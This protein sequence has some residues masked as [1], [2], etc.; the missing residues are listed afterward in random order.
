MKPLTERRRRGVSFRAKTDRQKDARVER[1]AQ[2][3]E[4][5]ERSDVNGEL[6]DCER[7]PEVRKDRLDIVDDDVR[8]DKTT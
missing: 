8:I 4:V 7:V 2:V 3:G 5:Q 6:N 1:L